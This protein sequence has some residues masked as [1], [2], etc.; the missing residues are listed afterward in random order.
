MCIHVHIAVEHI[1][2]AK[3]AR[4]KDTCNLNLWIFVKLFS[5]EAGCSDSYFQLQFVCWVWVF[6]PTMLADFK[7]TAYNAVLISKYI[8]LWPL[9]LSMYQTYAMLVSLLPASNK[10]R[11]LSLVLRWDF[12]PRVKASCCCCCWQNH[13][14]REMELIHLTPFVRLH[15]PEMGRDYLLERLG[16]SESSSPGGLG[17]NPGS[18]SY[19]LCAFIII[20]V[21]SKCHV[22]GTVPRARATKKNKARYYYARARNRQCPGVSTMTEDWKLTYF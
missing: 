9:S 18:A 12:L 13:G 3:V 10:L 21:T 4:S 20:W 19:W 14:L 15:H 7:M 5:R 8:K 22:P 6:K 11:S 16:V 17:L 1:S 2:R